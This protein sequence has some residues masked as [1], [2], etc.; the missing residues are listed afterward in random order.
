MFIPINYIPSLLTV[1]LSRLTHQVVINLLGVRSTRPGER[2]NSTI[3]YYL[4]TFICSLQH[5][6]INTA[7]VKRYQSESEPAIGVRKSNQWSVVSI[8]FQISSVEVHKCW[9]VQVLTVQ[10][11]TGAVWLFKK[12]PP[13]PRT[14]HL[15]PTAFRC[16]KAA[17]WKPCAHCSQCNHTIIPDYKTLSSDVIKTPGCLNGTSRKSDTH[18]GNQIHR[19]SGNQIQEIIQEIRYIRKSFRKS[20]TH[21]SK[22]LNILHIIRLSQ[23]KM[24]ASQASCTSICYIH[25]YYISSWLK[26]GQISHS[27]TLWSLTLDGV[28]NCLSATLTEW[29]LAGLRNHKTPWFCQRK[30]IYMY[31]YYISSWLKLGQISHSITLWSLILDGVINCL[32]VTLTEWEIGR[33]HVWTPVTL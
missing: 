11:L 5:S 33:A 14:S 25:V 3:V 27:I 7:K 2:D 18:S 29:G 22:N 15:Q 10:V 23:P 26:L 21:D 4:H 1:A 13:A 9:L 19:K 16:A 28:I 30:I 20:D 31:F 32:S 6:L 17:Q 8:L 12:L 24:F